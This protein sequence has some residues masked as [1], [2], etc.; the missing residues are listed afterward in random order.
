[1][2]RKFFLKDRLH[3]F[4]RWR[5]CP[6]TVLER[7]LPQE[8]AILD[9]GCGHGLFAYWMA[10]RSSRRRVIAYD[11]DQ[12][13]ILQARKCFGSLANLSFP[14]DGEALWNGSLPSFSAIVLVDVLAYLR[15]SEKSAIL[16]R[17]WERLVPGGILLLKE[18]DTRPLWKY[19]WSYLQE[20]LALNLFR[21]TRTVSGDRH[22]FYE[23]SRWYRS[24]LESLGF[25]TQVLP[26]ETHI[27]YPHV[28]VLGTKPLAG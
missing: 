13:K 5:T 9:W 4:F 14:E 16:K 19:A 3:L 2:E 23:S 8:G 17:C 7:L 28:V 22:P 21:L 6:F 24:Y 10:L 11:P 20:L 25:L 18:I 15:A 27:L 12:R 1:M 26:L